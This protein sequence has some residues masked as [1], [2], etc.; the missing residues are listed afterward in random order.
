MASELGVQTI[1]HTNGTDALTISSTGDVTMPNRKIYHW[2]AYRDAGDVG[3]NTDIVFDN[4]ISDSDGIYDNTTGI[5]T[6]PVTGVWQINFIGMSS[7]TAG[8]TGIGLFDKDNNRYDKI[9][10]RNSSSWY[11]NISGSVALALTSGDTI[12]WRVTH[13][14]IYGQTGNLVPTFSGFF[15]G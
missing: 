10:V 14:A 3:V 6:I 5:V 8:N 7:D 2:H 12:K 15:V 4:E 13:G 1:Q 9:A 11:G